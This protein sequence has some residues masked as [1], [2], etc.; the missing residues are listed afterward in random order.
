M[1]EMKNKTLKI[2][3]DGPSG[4]GKS[5]LARGVAARLGLTY[6]DTGALYRTVGLA[7]LRRGVS[8]EDGPGI[9]ALLPDLRVDLKNEDGNQ[10][11]FLDGTDVTGEIRTPEVSRYA[12]SVSALP[13]VRRFLF[14]LQRDIAERQDVIMDGRDI[15]T[16]ILPDA[17]LKIFLTASPE[18]RAR[19]R[20]LEL[21]DKGIAITLAELI[22]QQTERDRRD[23]SRDVAPMRPAEDAVLLDNSQM[24]LEETI[25]EVLRIAEEREL[26]ERRGS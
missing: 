22:S 13:E 20:L 11:V 5:T 7:A 12:S 16:V 15:G 21:R 23:A 8:A 2:A 10:R 26:T 17:D 14:A 18:A 24:N 6:V 9:L 3:I 4:A 1:P 25:A 19:R